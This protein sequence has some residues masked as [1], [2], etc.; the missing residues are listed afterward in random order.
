MNIHQ[1]GEQRHPGQ[2]DR[3]RAGGRGNLRRRARGGD[4]IAGY[5]YR[6][7]GVG[8]AIRGVEHQLGTEAEGRTTGVASRIGPAEDRWH[9]S[10]Q[11]Y[12]QEN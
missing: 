12:R 8:P 3:Q 9:A 10:S 1:T 2:W 7:T 4:V 5:Q 6:P 11:Q